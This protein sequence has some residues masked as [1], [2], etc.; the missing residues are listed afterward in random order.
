MQRKTEIYD[1]TLRDGAQGEGISFSAEDKIR[2]TKALDRLGV[3]YIEAGNPGSN[4]KDKEYFERIGRV[5]LKN[6]KICAFGSTRK[7]REKVEDNDNIK[8]LLAANTEVVAV[9]GKAWDMQVTKVIRTTLK[10]NL[11]MIKDTVKYLKDAGKEVI[12]DAEHFFDG[13]RENER[14]AFETLKSAYEGGADVLC[15]CD[16]N[17]ASYMS[18]IYNM[19]AKV[20]KSFPVKVAIHCH[21][22]TGIAVANSM[23]AVD[24]GAAMV[25]GTLIGM[26]ERCGNAD[27]S[28]V[29]AD[30][31]LKRGIS[32]IPEQNMALL[33]MTAR[34]IAEISNVKLPHDH[35]YVG[36]SAF[37]H[38]GGMHVDGVKKVPS[39]FEHI[40]PD[41]V[42]NER[43]ILLSEMSGRST[44]LSEIRK[45]DPTIMKN[46]N[47]TKAVVERIKELENEG[48]QFE[49]A[50][51]S[52]DLLI[53]K[54]LG[55]YKPF[56]TLGHYKVIGEHRME[57]DEDS[58]TAII[59]I[60][61]N[62]RS[63]ITAEQGKGPIDALDRA[64]K[65]AL[66]VF[67]P[68]IMNSRLIDY[69]VRV[70]EPREATASK[71][72]VLIET[73][74]G[75]ITWTNVGVSADVI[76]A[77]WIALVDAIEYKLTL[78]SESPDVAY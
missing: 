69:K 19:T 78:E 40:H 42:G 2:I 28:T 55:I 7:C 70:L 38:K 34:R 54:V 72:R 68:S 62:G 58:C 65:K 57:N 49:G 74:D 66:S 51:S 32:C 18:D 44:I 67:Y 45:I 33:T 13:C 56:F 75:A 76:E 12:F 21:N 59:K 36:K 24:A 3:S 8:A 25:Q 29:L 27:L 43:K 17:G 6:A 11:A 41:T 63:E 23:M 4:P 64:L 60:S 1:T 9:F 52:V 14:Y 50:H 35:P 77:S 20:V 5:Q 71:V 31:Q 30:L 53:R 37:A 48:Y 47:V 16:T 61:V 26:G 46:S 22:D 39:S 73:S 10:E 15:L